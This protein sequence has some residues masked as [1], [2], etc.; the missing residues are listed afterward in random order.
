[1]QRESVDRRFADEFS[2]SAGGS[3]VIVIHSALW[4]FG[5]HFDGNIRQLPRRLIQL[6]L[7]VIGPRRTLCFPAYTFSFCGSRVFDIAQTKSE[8]GALSEAARLWPGAVRTRQPVYS[9]ALIGPHAEMFRGLKAETAFGNFSAMEM[10]EHLNARQLMLGLRFQQAISIVHRAEEEA[11]VPYRY[12]KRFAGPLLNSGKPE[13]LAE[14]VFYVRAWDVEPL[15]DY[16]SVAAQV[17]AMPSYLASRPEEFNIES[18][19]TDDVLAV[20]RKAL[21]RDPYALVSNSAAV[22]NWAASG[23]QSEMSRLRPDERWAK[24]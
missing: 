14:E 13:G 7:D 17:R 1:M 16:S 4:S 23:K 6:M 3:E 8:V 2:Q 15:F 18:A 21:A 9:Y 24:P 12:F 10:F 19:G 11:R 22:E 5:H 20:S